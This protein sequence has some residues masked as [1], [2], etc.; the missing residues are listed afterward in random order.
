MTGNNGSPEVTRFAEPHDGRIFRDDPEQARG[1]R[2]RRLVRLLRALPRHALQHVGARRPG[3]PDRAAA[4][5]ARLL[6]RVLP[7]PAGVRVGRVRPRLL[8]RRHRDLPRQRLLRELAHPRPQ[9]RRGDPAAAREPDD[10]GRRRRAHLRRAGARPAGRGD[11]ARPGGAARGRG[12]A[13]RG[14]TTSSPGTT[15]SMRSSP[16]WSGSTATARTSEAPTS[17]RPTARCS[18][19][20]SSRRRTRGSASSSTRSCSSAR[21]RTRG[22]R[23]RSGGPRPT[24]S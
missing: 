19:G 6:R 13:R 9:G 10:A 7:L 24:R 22:S 2:D 12:P 15:A 17:S 14:S 3:R 11:P 4:Q 8:H 23:S 16:T 18:R 20:R 21:A 1:V 5:G